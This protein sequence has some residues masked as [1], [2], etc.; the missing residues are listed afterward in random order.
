MSRFCWYA[1]APILIATPPLIFHAARC[2]FFTA[3]ILLR[4]LPASTFRRLPLRCFAAVPRRHWRHAYRYAA[5]SPFFFFFRA[6][7]AVFRHDDVLLLIFP[8]R[9]AP[10]IRFFDFAARPPA[11]LMFDAVFLQILPAHLSPDACHVVDALFSPLIVTMSICLRPR[12][13]RYDYLLPA[14]YVCCH[15]DVV[16]M[17]LIFRSLRHCRCAWRDLPAF[18]MMRV[19]ACF[20]SPCR[21]RYKM[22]VTAWRRLFFAAPFRFVSFAFAVLS[23]YMPTL[24][25]SIF[26]RHFAVD[27][28]ATSLLILIILIDFRRFLPLW[29]SIYRFRFHAFDVVDAMPRFSPILSMI[30][31]S[32]PPDIVAFFFFFLSI[33][34]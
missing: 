24:S 29:F 20:W 1:A 15:V 2:R 3:S 33:F 23:D 10:F 4:S 30:Y 7:A 25:S 9:Y 34:R 14:W 28:Y 13:R 19:D 11:R 16:M 22:R 8:P 6:H 18:A 32:P 26:F 5:F 17:M 31:F 21:W 27:W 12:C